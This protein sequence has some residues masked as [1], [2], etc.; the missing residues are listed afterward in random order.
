MLQ[1]P[2]LALFRPLFLTCRTSSV[3]SESPT[4]EAPMAN[5]ASEAPPAQK[6][7]RTPDLRGKLTRSQ[8]AARLDVSISKVRTMERTA[9]HPEVIDGVHYFSGDDVDALARSLPASKRSRARLDEGQI[10]A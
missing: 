6:S 5:P 9:L 4:E 2:Y 7:P 10:A 3:V 8:V 1:D